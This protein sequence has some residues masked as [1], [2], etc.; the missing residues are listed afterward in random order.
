MTPDSPD[1]T[2]SAPEARDTTDV[3]ISEVKDSVSDVTI[4]ETK[5]S[6][7]DVT[8]S[9]AKEVT[10]TPEVKDAPVCSRVPELT[11]TSDSSDNVAVDESDVTDTEPRS[12]SEAANLLEHEVS[13]ETSSPLVVQQLELEE[14]SS[15]PSTAD[16][17]VTM[18]RESKTEKDVSDTSI[19]IDE[20][21]ETHT[22]EYNLIENEDSSESVTHSLGTKLNFS[23]V[24]NPEKE[25]T[26]A[27][28]QR[29]SSL[30]RG[31][32]ED[33]MPTTVLELTK[34]YVNGVDVW[35]ED[36]NLTKDLG[37]SP[38]NYS[39]ALLKFWNEIRSALHSEVC[40][41]PRKHE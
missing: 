5:D 34:D 36:N 11:V 33:E 4:S 39:S 23:E 29:L 9:E 8:I 17:D 25:V 7:T 18:Q 37:K 40:F 32:S 21:T 6:V 1:V 35:R 19:S 3:T 26:E 28:N 2:I 14:K 15:S 30:V 22:N 16:S 24:L 20:K 27:V 41:T 31:I 13:E 38:S 12:E 10:I